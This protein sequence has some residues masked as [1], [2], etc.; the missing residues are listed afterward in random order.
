MQLV[1]LVHASLFPARYFC[2]SLVLYRFSDRFDLRLPAPIPSTLTCLTLLAVQGDRSFRPHPPLVARMG[3]YQ[4]DWRLSLGWGTAIRFRSFSAAA[5]QSYRW[6]FSGLTYVKFRFVCCPPV[7]LFC[8]LLLFLPIHIKTALTLE[9]VDGNGPGIRR[10][11][12]CAG[13]IVHYSIECRT[14]NPL[15]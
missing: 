2:S 7:L 5:H 13:F 9:V 3:T 6:A 11:Y 14:F 15:V 4:F 1:W 10:S 12:V 8:Y